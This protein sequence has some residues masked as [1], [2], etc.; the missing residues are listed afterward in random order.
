MVKRR[1]ASRRKARWRAL[2][3]LSAAAAGG[4]LL[5]KCLKQIKQT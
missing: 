5:A 1:K 2:G 4:V 3:V